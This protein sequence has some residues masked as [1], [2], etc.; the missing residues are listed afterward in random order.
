MLLGGIRGCCKALEPAPV[1]ETKMV[2]VAK[3]SETKMIEVAKEK[4]EER[5]LS[6]VSLVGVG[7]DFFGRETEYEENEK[8][9]RAVEKKA[10]EKRE[11]K[12]REF[13]LREVP[14]LW[15]SYREIGGEI[16]VRTQKL[17]DLKGALRKFGKDPDADIDVK[18]LGN[19]IADLVRI[20]SD[21]LQKLEEAYLQSRKFTAS[22]QKAHTEK[23][24]QQVLE[25]SLRE[26]EMIERRFKDMRGIK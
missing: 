14:Q 22:G 7:D 16:K 21:L 6:E 15:Q 24:R 25:E 2:E 17:S 4:E 3:V 9:K 19:Q 26:A 11:K 1:F 23:L 18:R 13:S 20:R 8:A 10:A 5:I 12:L